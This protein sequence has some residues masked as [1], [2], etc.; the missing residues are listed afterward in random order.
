[1]HNDSEDDTPLVLMNPRHRMCWRQDLCQIEVE[2]RRIATRKDLEDDLLVEEPLRDNELG[3]PVERVVQRKD[4]S[5]TESVVH[6]REGPRR[7][8]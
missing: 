3:P 6:F 2:D 5:D 4:Y 1:M 7:G 8:Q